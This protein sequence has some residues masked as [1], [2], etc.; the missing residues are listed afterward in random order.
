MA[1][2]E[3]PPPAAPAA[4]AIASTQATPSAGGPS[5]EQA[6]ALAGQAKELNREGLAL[7]KAG[8]HLRA[9]EFFLRSR[10]VLPTSKNTTNAAITLEQLGRFDEA[11]ELYEELLLKY[12]GGLDDEDRAAIAPAMSALRTKVGSVEVS[13]N[14]GGEVTID[15]RRR[16]R[17]PFLT[18][19]RVLAGKHQIRVARVGYALFET[20][21]DS[22]AGQTTRVDA[23]LVP[24]KGIGTVVVEDVEGTKADVFVD[25]SKLGTTPWEGALTPGKHLVWLRAADGRGSAPS[26]IQV[27]EGQAAVVRLQARPLGPEVTIRV[28]PRTAAFEVGGLPLG[29]GTWSGRLPTGSYVL[30]ASERGYHPTTRR[31]E[32]RT[33]GSP[34][35]ETIRLTVDPDDPRWPRPKG[36]LIVGGFGGV[37]VGPSLAG[38]YMDECPDR[39]PSSS[40]AFGFLAGARGGYRFPSGF[41][42]EFDGGY[43]SVRQDVERTETSTFGDPA[44]EVT[45]DLEDHV[46]VRG[47]FFGLGASYRAKLGRLFYVGTRASVNLLV[48]TAGDPVEGTGTA[49]GSSGPLYVE[50]GNTTEVAVAPFVTPELFGGVRLGPI[51]IGLSV[52]LSFFVAQG[53][54]LSRGRVGVDGTAD[55]AN[56]AVVTNAGES[57]VIEGERAYGRFVILVPALTASSSF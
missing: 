12:A 28:E 21:F 18:P 6:V 44:T 22:T 14:V 29:P 47:P 34:V 35:D 53:P 26:W 32:L 37:L 11:L 23:K 16:G 17:L 46:H 43:L 2:T 49:N 7:V 27:L 9:L 40:A 19:L 55:P 4:T 51:D 45:Y 31:L 33:G 30:S 48:A 36:S 25:G 3:P 50:K 38:G 5:A 39:C 54:E 24:L 57:E 8:D 20:T 56:P 13:S 42:I 15:G 41:A 1:Q 52:G 10:A